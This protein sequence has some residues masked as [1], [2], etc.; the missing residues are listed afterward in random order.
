MAFQKETIIDFSEVRKYPQVLLEQMKL[1]MT[2]SLLGFISDLW[3][4]NNKKPDVI[5]KYEQ[6]R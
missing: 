3:P 2:S 6:G 1:C 5:E 4:G